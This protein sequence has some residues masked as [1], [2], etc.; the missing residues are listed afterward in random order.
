MTIMRLNLIVLVTVV[1]LTGGFVAG[2]LVPGVKDLRRVRQEVTE[3]VGAV[4][5]AQGQVGNVSELY[6]SILRTGEQLADFRLHLPEDRQFGE[7]LNDISE[8]LKRCEIVEYVVQPRP[9]RQ[10]DD[11]RL[12][13]S[14]KLAKGTV[15]LPV[16]VSFET[17]FGKL[18]DFLKH[19]ETLPRL[20]HVE[21]M[22][23][24]NNEEQPGLVKVE[25]ILQTY[26][27]PA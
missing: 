27:R 18:F 25:L 11:S 15:I 7:F 13:P 16:F 21:S 6:A 9:A 14:F 4:Q 5:A 19:M 2:L 8:N 12:T 1:V 22:K 24:S 10:L 20:F 3:Q 23:L 17:D 26:H